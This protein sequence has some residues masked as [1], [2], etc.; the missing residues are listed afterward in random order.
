MASVRHK[1]ALHRS[2]LQQ[3]IRF[4][5][6]AGGVLAL[7]IASLAVAFHSPEKVVATTTVSAHANAAD[8]VNVTSRGDVRP[9]LPEAASP[10][11]KGFK[12]ATTTLDLHTLASDKSPVLIEI[13][14][15]KKVD[16]TGKTSR[17]FA[18]VVHDGAVRWVTAKYLSADRPLGGAPCPSGSAMESGIQR[19]TIRVH[20]AVCAQFPEIVRYIGLGG[21]GEHASGRAIDIM[22]GAN[23]AS[24]DAIAAF[25]MAHA[26]E[27]GVS[28]IIYRQRIWTVQR[29]GDGWRS[30]PDR[31][32][33]TAN[34][35]DHVHVS[36]YG[37]AGTL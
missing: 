23:R 20:R 9:P 13:K 21:G 17:G 6:P 18:E 35:M 15:G 3:A 34:H 31:G 33:A 1:H 8:L 37:N 12:Y 24:G 26:R 32:S 2:L 22:L 25:C 28:Q 7:V 4:S 5:L 19:D 29:A 30:M 36:T 14:A 16:V 27:F 11:I 10:E